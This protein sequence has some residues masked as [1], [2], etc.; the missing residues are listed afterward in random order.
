MT[1]KRYTKVVLFRRLLHQARPYWRQIAAILLLDV[2]A[3]PLALLKPVPLQLVVDNVVGSARLPRYLDALLPGFAVRSSLR[4]LVLAV[5]LTV[6]VALFGQLQSL[7]SYLLKTQT[8]ERLTLDFR[9]RIFQ[10]LQRLSLS[11]HDTRGSA[12][13]IYRLQDD[14]P[15]LQWL[16]IYGVIPFVFESVTLLAMM[17]VIVRIDWQLVLVAL[18]ITPFLVL[19]VRTYDRRIEGRYEGVKQLESSAL[20]VVQEVLT[21]VRIVKAFGREETE[22]ERYSRRS[23][24]GVRAR[25]R[26]VFAEGAFGLIVNVTI[27]VG[28]ALVLYIGV[29]HVQSGVL[30]LGSLLIVIAYLGQLYGPLETISKEG[31]SVQTYLASIQRAFELLDEVPEVVER[32]G[33]RPLRCTAGAVEFRNVSFSYDGKSPVLRDVSLSIPAGARVGI[34]GKTGAGKTTLL[35]LLIRFYDPSSG[36]ILLDEADLR[37]YRLADLRNQFAMVLQDAVLFSTSIA[38]NI[39][40]ARPGA[41]QQEIIKAAK[42][43]EAHDFIVALPDGYKTL[44]GERGML[45]SGGERQRISLAR[46]FLKDAPILLLDEPTSA[47][48]AGTETAIL[49]AME[50]LMKGRTSFLISHRLSALANCDVL[51]KIEDGRLIEVVLPGASTVKEVVPGGGTKRPYVITKR[52]QD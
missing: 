36:Q 30:T 1:A 29:R 26:L 2:L 43:A 22:Q 40:Y 35:S 38:E 31:A 48:D 41:T 25:I 33:A 3:T 45:L 39:A 17:Y 19:Y 23:R 34:A 42:S 52:A 50:R 4:I 24:E 18:G 7:T 13:S 44:V 21:A 51:L 15:S 8:G 12:D 32:P 5:V 14:A 27:A 6:C 46:A 9:T 11:F 47:V 10:H 49:E 16:T 28:T 20:Q 37:D